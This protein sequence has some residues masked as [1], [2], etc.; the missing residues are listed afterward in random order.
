[1]ERLGSEV[2]LHIA[3]AVAVLAFLLYLMFGPVT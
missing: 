2:L 3:T 1:M